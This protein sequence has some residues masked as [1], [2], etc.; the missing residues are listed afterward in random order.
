MSAMSRGHTGHDN[1]LMTSR[2]SRVSTIASDSNESMSELSMLDAFQNDGLDIKQHVY[3]VCEGKLQPL[4]FLGSNGLKEDFAE[5]L[6]VYGGR[7]DC[8]RRGHKT[9]SGGEVPCDK[10]RVAETLTGL[11]AV[12][13]VQLLKIRKERDAGILIQ[14]LA[15]LGDLLVQKRDH[16]FPPEYFSTRNI[17][18]A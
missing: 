13:V 4:V 14:I 6:D 2:V 9:A 12:M 7:L 8:C 5:L 17:S 1:L 11:Y 16:F 18:R 10:V 15:H 3:L